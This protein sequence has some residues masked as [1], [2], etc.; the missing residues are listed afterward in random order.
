MGSIERRPGDRKEG[1][2]EETGGKE[3]DQ[4]RPH[5]AGFNSKCNRKPLEGFKKE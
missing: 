1:W 5:R 4:A 2:E 3:P